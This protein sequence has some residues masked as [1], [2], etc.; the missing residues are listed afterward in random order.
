MTK[1]LKV[2]PNK[3]FRFIQLTLTILWTLVKSLFLD[4]NWEDFGSINNNL[5]SD[6]DR[7]QMGSGQSNINKS[8]LDK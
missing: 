1:S 6:P 8:L 4:D 7:P 5:P 2:L 3:V